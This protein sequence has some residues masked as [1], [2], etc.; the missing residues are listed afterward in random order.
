MSLAAKKEGKVVSVGRER[1]ESGECGGREREENGKSR[2]RERGKRGEC[3]ERRK[4]KGGV[5]GEK[6]VKVGCVGER[7]E[8]G[9]CG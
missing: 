8:R 2:G 1:G 4:G 7:V 9:E 3:G 5:C 6:E